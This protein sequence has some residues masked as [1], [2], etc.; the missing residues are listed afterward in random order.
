MC[1]PLG[2]ACSAAFYLLCMHRSESSFRPRPPT[3]PPSTST[4]GVAE[5]K[6][7][8]GLGIWMLRFLFWARAV[9]HHLSSRDRGCIG[10]IGMGNDEGG[11]DCK[12]DLSPTDPGHTAHIHAHTHRRAPRSFLKSRG[13]SSSPSRC[14][15]WSPAAA[16]AAVAAT[17]AADPPVAAAAA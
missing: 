12:C 8:E 2:D 16:A 3:H 7:S 4:A 5:G 10:L 6:G 9:G 17:V 14:A 13:S 11:C 15:P 1:S